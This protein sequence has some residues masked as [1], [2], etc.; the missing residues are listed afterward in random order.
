M[1]T[2]SSL[3]SPAGPDRGG[4]A[5]ATAMLI[6]RAGP[7][8]QRSA[9]EAD[10]CAQ[11]VVPIW[12]EAVGNDAPDDRAQDEESAVGR[13]H[14]S[15][16]V[17]RLERCQQPVTD[18]ER[19]PEDRGR[20]PRPFAQ[21]APEREGAADLSHGGSDEEQRRAHQQR[22]DRHRRERLSESL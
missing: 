6:L 18:Q 12:A 10:E 5:G 7:G 16:L 19:R 21:R 11:H 20:R 1:S 3:R 17:L 2:I 14:A 4:A 15:E 8:N 22:L 13:Q 9:A